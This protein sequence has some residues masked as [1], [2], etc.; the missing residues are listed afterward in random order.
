MCGRVLESEGIKTEKLRKYIFLEG[1]LEAVQ[2]NITSKK[3]FTLA[4]KL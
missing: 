4:R 3:G 1:V 2:T